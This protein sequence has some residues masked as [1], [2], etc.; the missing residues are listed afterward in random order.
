MLGNCQLVSIVLQ[1]RLVYAHH[2]LSTWVVHA[3]IV[4]YTCSQVLPD[5]T[6]RRG[7]IHVLLIGDPSTAKSQFL[8]FAAQVVSC[9]LKP[10]ALPPVFPSLSL[11]KKC[12]AVLLRHPLLCVNRLICHRTNDGLYDETECLCAGT[13][14]TLH[15]REGL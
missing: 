3:I 5:G 4:L 2:T 7:D 8:K 14:G 15:I 12:L 13:R 9:C 1:S 6:P 10:Q 11:S